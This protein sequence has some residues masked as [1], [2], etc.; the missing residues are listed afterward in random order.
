MQLR[1]RDVV[2]ADSFA[3]FTV[4]AI[5]EPFGRN[6]I[7]LPAKPLGIGPGQLGPGKETGGLEDRAVGRAD[8]AFDAVID[9][10][11]HFIFTTES[12]ENAEK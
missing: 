5:L 1:D 12:T 11:F 8:G 3:D 7:L 10:G 2:R 6:D 9:I 4:I